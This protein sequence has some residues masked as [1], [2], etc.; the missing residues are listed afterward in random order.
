MFH[1][2]RVTTDFVLQIVTSRF[3][4]EKFLSQSAEKRRRGAISVSDFLG[5]DKSY[6]SEG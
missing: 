4:V 6:A 3:S 5:I 1:Y 2:F